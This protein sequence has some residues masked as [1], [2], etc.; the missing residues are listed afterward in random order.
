MFP[1]LLMIKV[2][3]AA[4]LNHFCL[5]SLMFLLMKEREAHM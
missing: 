5:Y 4:K 3:Y 1:V 2:F